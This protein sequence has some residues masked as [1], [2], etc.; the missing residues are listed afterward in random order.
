MVFLRALGSVRGTLDAAGD[1]HALVSHDPWGQVERGTAPTFG[2]TGEFLQGDQ[3]YLCAVGLGAL[4][5]I[6]L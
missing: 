2:F 6:R 5:H 4:T 1:L 3:I